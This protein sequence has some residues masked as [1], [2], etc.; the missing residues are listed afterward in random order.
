LGEQVDAFFGTKQ[1]ELIQRLREYA[2]MVPPPPM[3]AGFD[4]TRAHALNPTKVWH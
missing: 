2:T 3:L 4:R 1:D